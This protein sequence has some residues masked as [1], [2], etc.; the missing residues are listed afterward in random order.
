ML[1]FVPAFKRK[2]DNFLPG[3]IPRKQNMKKEE[4]G[5]EKASESYHFSLPLRRRLGGGSPKEKNKQTPILSLFIHSFFRR[6]FGLTI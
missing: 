3:L 1:T 5:D 2:K 4:E 6:D